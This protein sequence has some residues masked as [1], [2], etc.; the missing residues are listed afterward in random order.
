MRFTIRLKPQDG[1]SLSSY[2]FRCCQVNSISFESIWPLIRSNK[3]GKCRKRIMKSLD[4]NPYTHLDLKKQLM[5]QG[6]LK[7]YLNSL[8]IIY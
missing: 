3:T 4:S 5:L 8:H 6:N 7:K 2:L 1:E